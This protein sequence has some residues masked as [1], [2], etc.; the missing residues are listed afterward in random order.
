MTVLKGSAASGQLKFPLS[1]VAHLDSVPLSSHVPPHVLLE[2]SELFG[3]NTV[4]H[5]ALTSADTS[6]DSLVRVVGVSLSLGTSMGSSS[7]EADKSLLAVVGVVTISLAESKLVLGRPALGNKS[8]H[9]SSLN[10]G[11]RGNG[12]SN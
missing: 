7:G 4:I 10:R 1:G 5:G 8:G 11:S 6:G 2:V 9:M 12:G 3:L